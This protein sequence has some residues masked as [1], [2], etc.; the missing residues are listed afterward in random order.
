M[1]SLQKENIIDLFVVIDDLLP[2]DSA[3]QGRGRPLL[4]SNSEL[5]TI[6][7]WNTLYVKQQTL[8]DIYQWVTVD[9]AGEFPTVPGYKGFVAY[10][11]RIVP[12]LVYIIKQLLIQDQPLQ[13]TDSTMLEVC[14]LVRADT[15][16]VARSIARFGKNHQG[17]HY[18]LK[19]HLGITIHNQISGIVLTPANVYDAQ[20]LPKLISNHTKVVV[21][22][23]HYGAK[24]MKDHLWQTKGVFV[25]APPHHS[26]KKKLLASWQ[27]LLLR[28]RR[29]IESVFDYLKE[30]LHI[31]S[32]FPRSVNGLLLHYLRILLGYQI[33]TMA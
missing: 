22:D 12:V 21:G 11:Q 32:S 27:Y 15:H 18:G 9:Y 5:V 29:K 31:Q 10:C 14:K 17:W 2:H 24:A 19:L 25:L 7:V 3:Q 16:R 33:I 30:H 6:L 1:L 8:A 20:V 23:S 28:F 4:L 26:Q 13:I